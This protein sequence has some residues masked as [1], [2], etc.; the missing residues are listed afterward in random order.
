MNKY[1]NLYF[2]VTN[3]Q[4]TIQM[5]TRTIEMLCHAGYNAFHVEF[6][7]EKIDI[8]RQFVKHLLEAVRDMKRRFHFSIGYTVVCRNEQLR[9][10]YLRDLA[11]K[12]VRIRLL[13]DNTSQLGTSLRPIKKLAS[14]IPK[15]EVYVEHY[16]P[17]F[18]T[19]SLTTVKK[20]PI[21]IRFKFPTYSDDRYLKLF[22]EWIL[23]KDSA[24]LGNFSDMLQV[25]L[26][27][28]Q[29]CCEHDSCMGSV[30]SIDSTGMMYWCKNKEVETALANINDME[31]LADCF[32][33]GDFEKYL[34]AHYV[35]REYC[36]AKCDYFDICQSG[37]PLRCDMYGHSNHCTEQEYINAINHI[38]DKL[39]QCLG[40]SDLALINK[41]ARTSILNA[42]A[43]MQYR[44]NAPC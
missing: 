20:I 32:N 23:S 24:E 28:R 16:E 9:K 7:F 44:L 40:L 19:L 31:S 18:D 34:D 41:H 11:K 5:L 36:Q 38:F 25:I 12:G 1:M 14:L 6:I 27:N 17:P 39:R 42:I 22:D 2:S 13:I 26:M 15:L 21:P 37:C 33:H 35:K 30:L 29:N 3:E 4:D 10:V 43:H 8:S